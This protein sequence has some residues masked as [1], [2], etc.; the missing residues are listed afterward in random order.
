VELVDQFQVG[1]KDSEADRN[2]LRAFIDKA[3]KT[4]ELDKRQPYYQYPLCGTYEV[5]IP[6]KLKSKSY[7]GWTI[8]LVFVGSATNN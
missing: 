5:L 8:H 6:A 3:F 1:E 4:V 7:A 2:R